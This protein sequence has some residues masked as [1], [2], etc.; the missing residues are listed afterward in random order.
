[1]RRLML[2]IMLC[3]MVLGATPAL[4]K[5]IGGCPNGASEKWRLVDVSSLYIPPEVN[6]TTLDGNGDGMTCIKPFKTGGYVFV[7]N[8]VG[9]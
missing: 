5:N 7:D 3:L 6:L 9:N 4:A 2:A 1:M 8:N